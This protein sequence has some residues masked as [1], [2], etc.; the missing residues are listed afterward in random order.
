MPGYDYYLSLPFLHG[1]ETILVQLIIKAY[2]VLT[3]LSID[4]VF[5]LFTLPFCKYSAS[6]LQE[7]VVF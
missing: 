4:L 5:I 6:T 1:Q 7:M 2:H 3:V